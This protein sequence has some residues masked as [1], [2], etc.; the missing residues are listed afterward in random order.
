LGPP[1]WVDGETV[2]WLEL[3]EL[4]MAS[5]STTVTVAPS[6]SRAATM[7]I[8]RLERTRLSGTDG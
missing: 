5:T 3:S 8:M 1:I 7:T 6:A 4:P 2:L